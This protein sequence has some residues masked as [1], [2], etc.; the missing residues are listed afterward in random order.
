M[1]K[2]PVRRLPTGAVVKV[3]P[4]RPSVI[5]QLEEHVLLWSSQYIG[6]EILRVTYS[7]QHKSDDCCMCDAGKCLQRLEKRP[8]D[9]GALIVHDCRGGLL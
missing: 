3:K 4:R 7:S 5:E 8:E 9:G 1:R 6:G 2:L